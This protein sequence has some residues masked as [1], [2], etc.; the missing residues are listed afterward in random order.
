MSDFADWETVTIKGAKPSTRVPLP[1]K[2]TVRIS[3]EA[4]RLRK[5]ESDDP[6]KP[7]ILDPTSRQE[8]VMRRVANKWSQEDLN[9]QCKFSV[10]TIR[11]FEAG[12]QHPTTQQLNALNRV[13]KCGLKLS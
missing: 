7:K 6:P 11:E 9:R 4:A 12:R 8:M 10:N 2:T 1:T 13:L 3:N 5:V